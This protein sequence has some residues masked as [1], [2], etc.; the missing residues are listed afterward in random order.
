MNANESTRV[1]TETTLAEAIDVVSASRTTARLLRN[2][3]EVPVAVNQESGPA[4]L[5]LT[6]TEASQVLAISRSKLYELLNAG[7][8]PS[9]HIGR[10]RRIRVK[11]VE[12]FVNGGG[13]EYL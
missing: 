5:L 10:S 9:V 1:L 7:H 2:R 6:L 12:D 11:D 3:G 8:L 13:H 4:K